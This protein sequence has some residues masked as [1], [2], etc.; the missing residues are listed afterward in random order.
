MARIGLG[1]DFQHRLG[2]GVGFDD[3]IKETRSS[4]SHLS[5]VGL[6]SMTEVDIFLQIA[7]KLPIIHHFTGV[8]P[9]GQCGLNLDALLYQKQISSALK[10]VWCLEDIGI[11][12][13]GPYSIPYF[14]PP[15]LCQ[16]VLEQTVNGIH[17]INKVVDIPFLAEFPSCSF[18]SGDLRLEYFFSK[19]IDE[20]GCGMVLDVSHVLSYTI[21][22]KTPAAEVLEKLPLDAVVEIHVAGGSIHPEFEWRYR[23]THSEPVLEATLDILTLAIA[24]CRNLRAITYE[25]GTGI[26]PGLILSD[27]DRLEGVAKSAGFSANF[28][29]ES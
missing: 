7:D 9:A 8:A 18:V 1:I 12:N 10:A 11:W 6:S 5:I 24:Q 15:V 16:E 3:L 19:L 29:M 27:L 28:C 23:D 25:I 14:S 13:I 20:T 4:L 22:T 21:Y 26:T 17:E 2:Y